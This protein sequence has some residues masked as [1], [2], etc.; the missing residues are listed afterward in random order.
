MV[1][2]C[3]N[4]HCPQRHEPPGHDTHC[5]LCSHPLVLTP[6]YSQPVNAQQVYPASFLTGFTY[7]QASPA[8]SSAFHNSPAASGYNLP[9]S[10]HAQVGQTSP[11]VQDPRSPYIS[12]GCV[13]ATV[14]LPD[15]FDFGVII[16]VLRYRL[17][18]NFSLLPSSN[19]LRI[20]TS[21]S[22]TQPSVPVMNIAIE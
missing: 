3:V 10:N 2:Q 16:D 6:D 22:T 12:P 14:C 8:N 21:E 17:T 19:Q 1:N 20:R 9:A 4:V 15:T 18:K 11:T 5:M 13:P 7:G